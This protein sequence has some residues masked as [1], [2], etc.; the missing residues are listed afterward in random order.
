M[1]CREI[2]D[3]IWKNAEQDDFRLACVLARS[4]IVASPLYAQASHHSQGG[5]EGLASALQESP[6]KKISE[7]RQQRKYLEAKQLDLKTKRVPQSLHFLCSRVLD[8]LIE[9]AKQLGVSESDVYACWQTL[10]EKV[11]R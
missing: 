5:C 8:V 2:P 3:P 6:A 4:H 7:F 9:H 1:K 10:V 11:I